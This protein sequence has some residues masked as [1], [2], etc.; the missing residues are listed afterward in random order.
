MNI[1]ILTSPQDKVCMT[2]IVTLIIHLSLRDLEIKW[3]TNFDKIFFFVFVYITLLT[4]VIYRVLSTAT[5]L[6]YQMTQQLILHEKNIKDWLKP[7]SPDRHIMSATWAMVK[8]CFTEWCEII[9]ADLVLPWPI[10]ETENIK[11][12]WKLKISPAFHL[13]GIKT[14]VGGSVG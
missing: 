8:I 14:Q 2:D 3:T 12:T 7:T 5:T 1:Q 6:S 9:Q 10:G 4:Y 11:V 13:T